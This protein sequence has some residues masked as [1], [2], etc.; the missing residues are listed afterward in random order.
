MLAASRQKLLCCVDG[1]AVGLPAEKVKKTPLPPLR[2]I[3]SK[4]GGK[5]DIRHSICAERAE[6]RA[7]DKEGVGKKPPPPLPVRR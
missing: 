1:V 6:K 3:Q 5:G 2:V 7:F 4:I